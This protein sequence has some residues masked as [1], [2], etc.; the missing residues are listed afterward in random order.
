MLFYMSFIALWVTNKFNQFKMRIKRTP[1]MSLEFI[2][3]ITNQILIS[4]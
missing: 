4:Y 3:E 1:G 2:V